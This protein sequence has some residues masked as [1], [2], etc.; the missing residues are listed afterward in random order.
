MVRDL[1]RRIFTARNAFLFLVPALLLF[2]LPAV[3]QAQVGPAQTAALGWIFDRGKD[4]FETGVS[5]TLKPIVLLI[6]HFAAWILGVVGVFFNWVVLKTV[7]Q[8]GLYF[9]TSEGMLLA[10]GVIRD[11]SNIALLFGF[12]FMGVLLIL[13]VEGGGHGHGGGISARRAIPRLL[14]FAVLLN[15]SLFTTQFVIDI[16]NAFASQLV[17]LAGT[18]CSTGDEQTMAQCANEGISGKILSAVGM[19]TIWSEDPEN[20][21]SELMVYLGVTIF[22]LITATVLLAAGI[23]L[24]VRVVVLS[25]LMVTSPIGFA[26]MVI[27]GLGKIAKDWWHTL[28]SQSFYA[29]VMLLLVFI[30]LKLAES[31][32]PKGQSLIEALT[33]NSSS[34]AANLQIV[35]VFAV[36]IGFMIASLI[37]ASKIGAMGAG[38]A[39]NAA[40]AT[41]FGSVTRMSNLAVGGGMR[42]LRY[43]IERTPLA[44]TD[45][46]QA[47]VNRVFLPLEKTNLD[48]RRAGVGALLGA[49]GATTGAKA[50]EHA[51]YGDM[52]HEVSDIRS[53]K[54]SERLRAEF[55]ARVANQDLEANA[56]AN[57]GAGKLTDKDIKHLNSLSTKELEELHGIKEG[58]AA[59]AQNLTP[60]QFSKL[61]DSKDLSD[62][63]KGKLSTN[64]LKGIKDQRNTVLEGMREKAAAKDAGDAAAEKAADAKI[65][66]AKDKLKKWSNKDLERLAKSG[67]HG[68]LLADQDFAALLTD[69]QYDGLM[70]SNELSNSQK[71]RFEEVRTE[72]RFSTTKAAETLGN[73][74]IEDVA[75]LKGAVLAKPHV[76][77]SMT[78]RQLAAINPDKLNEDQL[79]AIAAHIRKERTAG[80]TAGKEFDALLK[81]NPKVQERWGG[82]V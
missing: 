7:F 69:D 20:T 71:L 38:L 77:G 59:I 65:K 68:D 74:S 30:S 21:G 47:A 79:K 35:V 73:M 10:W 42:G 33:A 67:A 60:E 70:K 8:F 76:H 13:N 40:S 27:P 17:V 43:G 64:R 54:E 25:F 6:L 52:A 66:E 57:N 50:A 56:H 3:A 1:M 48:M 37:A 28:L 19:S 63:A 78:G 16:S 9:G 62:D 23:M 49:A 75:K 34:L 80:T 81:A 45:I 15:F 61:M 31:L 29:P 4:V 32:S 14:I 39:T 18:E 41:V 11:I 53:G 2:V 72:G 26:G 46:G 24:V 51:T 12:I 5:F 22:I 44:K 55:E 36:V 58:V 82:V